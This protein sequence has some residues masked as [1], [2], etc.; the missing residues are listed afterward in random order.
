MKHTIIT[1]IIALTVLM[2]CKKESIEPACPTVTKI[3]IIKDG[4][5][6]IVNHKIT[7]SNGKVIDKQLTRLTVGSEYCG[8]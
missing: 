6:G 8:I 3:E 5:G 4:S 2:G 7:L 1:A